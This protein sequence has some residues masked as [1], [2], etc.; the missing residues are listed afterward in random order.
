MVAFAFVAA[1]F[2][3]MAV[4][5]VIATAAFAVITFF[6]LVEAGAASLVAPTATGKRERAARANGEKCGYKK[7]RQA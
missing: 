1:L 7:C 2:A 5:F 6:V 4:A 3:L